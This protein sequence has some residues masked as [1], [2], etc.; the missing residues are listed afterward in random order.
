[1]YQFTKDSTVCFLGD[2]ITA[3]GGWIR[4]IYDYYRLERKIPCRLYNCG[5]PGDRA[6]HALWRLE[7]TVFCYEPTDV[8]GTTFADGTARFLNGAY[9][10]S[11]AE[12]WVAN[13][14]SDDTRWGISQ[15]S[16]LT[17]PSV[18]NTVELAIGQTDS[19]DGGAFTAGV[20]RTSG[21]ICCWNNGEYV[22]TNELVFTLPG[23]DR[24]VAY[25]HSDGAFK[26]EK[27]TLADQGA[28]KWFYFANEGN[29]NYTKNIWIGAG[30]LNFADGASA[31]TAYSCGLR[32]ND[33]VY[34]RPWHSDYTIRTKPNST[35]DF[36]ICQET[37]IGTDDESGV[38]RTVTCDGLIH[39]TGA[40]IVEGSG[41]FVVN[42]PGNMHSG[43][44]TVRSRG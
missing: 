16:S 15:G 9:S 32:E 18:D 44:W 39:N 10:L 3:N 5:V 43:T 7:E 26:F 27:I 8:V 33:V 14:Y 4:R 42:H 19:V 20:V 37:H 23:A 29:Y 36:V 38:A 11:T 6:E 30:G 25:Q 1:M 12:D 34:L 31:N 28:S 13:T 35:T 21:R 24:H 17:V 41:T 2:S 22:V 40:A